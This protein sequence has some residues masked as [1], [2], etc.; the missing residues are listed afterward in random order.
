MKIL[1]LKS[2][3]SFAEK[4]LLVIWWIECAL[5][6]F[7][8]IAFIFLSKQ[9]Y[10]LGLPVT[11]SETTINQI[12][13]ID[14]SS[15][16]GILKVSQGN[17][18]VHLKGNFI[19][20]F[21]LIL[22]TSLIGIVTL[23]ITH[24]LRMIFSNFRKNVPFTTSNI[25]RIRNIAYALLIFAVFQWCFTILTK[26]TLL[27]IFKLGKIG[28]TCDFSLGYFMFGVMLLLISEILKKGLLLEEERKLII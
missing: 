4:C 24:Q 22:V 16:L 9:G 21:T 7:A 25:K 18:Y 14:H 28:L 3:T 13:P 26:I 2:W 15:F 12:G 19:T 11:F 1:G 27:S 20:V 10:N 6:V 17:F 8:I 5:F 23:I